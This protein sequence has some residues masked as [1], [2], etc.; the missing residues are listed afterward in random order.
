[1][2]KLTHENF[3]DFLWMK[4]HVMKIKKIPLLFQLIPLLFVS[5]ISLIFRYDVRATI[6][7]IAPYEAVSQT[8]NRF[9]GL[10]ESEKQAEMLAEEERY[11]SLYRNEVEE[12]MYKG[13]VK[14]SIN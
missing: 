10:S 11:Y 6:S 14:I 2:E 3:Q 12:E 7:D 13:I 9:D 1:M 5:S 8:F 4:N